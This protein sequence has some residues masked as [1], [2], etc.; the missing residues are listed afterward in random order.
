M[1]VKGKRYRALWFEDGVVKFI[2]QR[3]LP[4]AFEIYTAKTIDDVTFAITDMVVRG[5]PSIGAAATYGMVLGKKELEKTAK[6]LQQTR[7]T[8]HDLFYAINYMIKEI[9]NGNKALDAANTYVEDVVD[10]CR[11]IG[12]YGEKLIKNGMKILTQLSRLIN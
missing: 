1:N 4:Y 12:E 11:R 2:D 7:P 3:K 6:K 9:N 10:R 5:A 8:A